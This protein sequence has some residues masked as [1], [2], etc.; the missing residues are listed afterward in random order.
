MAAASTIKQQS[1]IADLGN[2]YFNG[3]EL[4]L[5]QSQC[6]GI[7]HYVEGMYYNLTKI[8]TIIPTE[9]DP[10]ADH[11]EM[12]NDIRHNAQLKVFSGGTSSRDFNKHHNFIAR[13]VHDWHHYLAGSDF[14]FE[15]ELAAWR[16]QCAGKC[17]WM[18]EYLFSEIV[19]QA[20]AYHYIGD[21]PDKQRVVQ[22]EQWMINL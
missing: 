21:Y 17:M 5:S 22:W 12:F 10:Y 9:N 16:K 2:H 20:A 4:I 18:R 15:G 8:L 11:L 13:A 1:L 6:L 19:L 14:T 7:S 3:P